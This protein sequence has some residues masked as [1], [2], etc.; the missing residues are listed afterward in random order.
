MRTVR[1]LSL[2][3]IFSTICVAA[4][5]KIRV[6]D[7]QTAVV[8]A[9]RITVLASDGRR[10]IA[11]LST[12][13]DGTAIIPG[14][15]SGSYQLQVLAPGF[16]ERVVTANV[17]AE[18][19]LTVEL[20][21][22]TTSETVVVSATA[23]PVPQGQSGSAVSVL[24]ETTLTTLNPTQLGDVLRFVPGVTVASSGRN[25]GLSTLFVRGG[26]SRYNKVII[27]GVPSND[28][29]GSFD[30]GVV[31][32]QEVQRI[33]VLRGAASSLYGAD[34]MTSVVQMW[35]ATGSTP[36][37]QLTFGAEG[38]TFGTARGFAALSGARG[39]FDY[40]VF[41]EQFNTDGQ[42]INDEYS[43]S[44]QGLNLGYRLT[45][46]VSL[47]LRTRHSNNRT[48]VP[49]NWWF[50]G[51]AIIAPDSDAY[52]RQNNL[53]ASLDLNIAAPGNWQHHI[54]GF[55][56]NHYR[57]NADTF[58]DAGRSFD[59]PFDSRANFN[60]AGFQGTSEYTP[61]QWAH[62]ILGYYFETRTSSLIARSFHSAS[63]VRP[64]RTADAA[65]KQYSAN[66]FSTGNAFPSWAARDT[67][68]TEALATRFCRAQP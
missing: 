22:A 48:G 6:V 35:S 44:S 57:K 32:L 29:G 26:E 12:A 19:P 50:N 54:T 23:T 33:E 55:E 15:S 68:T 43:N 17:P 31:P 28:P 52:A 45:D 14:L 62:T 63:P 27:D 36:V 25:G 7:P 11:V 51:A 10:P 56:Y 40:N 38:G 24:D 67:N 4:D 34:A 16:A 41:G 53:S 65:I 8:Q 49:S 58:N 60:R 18:Q 9:A 59:D 47:R 64:I 39:R 20:A 2:F 21:I 42:G 30:F 1:I 61:R 5:L 46:R 37:P 3:F 66:S 13:P